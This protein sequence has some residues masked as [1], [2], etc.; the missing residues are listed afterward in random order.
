MDQRRMHRAE[1][2]E[3]LGVRQ[4][5]AGPGDGLPRRALEIGLA[6]I[7]APARDRQH[8]FDARP[9]DHL[10]QR[11]IVVPARIPALGHFGDRRAGRT[12]GREHAELQPV[13]VMHRDVTP[14][15]IIVGQRIS[16]DEF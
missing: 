7:A 9:V 8:E 3:V 10:R 1:H 11:K 12:I 5:P 16:P 4:Q 14:I 2:V 15:V 13:G 6:A